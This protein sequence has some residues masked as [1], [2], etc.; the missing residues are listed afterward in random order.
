VQE[1]IEQ[2]Q[3]IKQLLERNQDSCGAAEGTTALQL[4]FI[5]VQAR[6]DA[7]VEVQ[8]SENMLDVQFDFYKWVVAAL[9]CVSWQ[10]AALQRLDV[11]DYVCAMQCRTR[12][13][14]CCNECCDVCC[15]ACCT[16]ARD[17]GA[18]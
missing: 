10:H 2:Q 5:L 13:D 16:A 7:T 3:A 17:H 8:I 11:L 6:P 4:P 14:G 15:D 18:C 1:L 12:Y 9:V